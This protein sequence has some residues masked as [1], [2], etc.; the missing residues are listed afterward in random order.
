MSQF[1][2]PESFFLV[3]VDD[4]FN[5]PEIIV[6]Y[7]K[8]LSKRGGSAPGVRSQDIWEID[9]VLFQVIMKKILSCY[10]DLDYIEI[11][12]KNSFM[13]FQ[14]IS[15]YSED[16]NDI[17]NRGWIHQDFPSECLLAGLIYL[18]PNIDPDSGTSLFDLKSSEGN[19]DIAISN[20]ASP[21]PYT[22]WKNQSQQSHIK[23]EE[24]FIEKVK[25]QNKFNRLILYDT[26]E[27]HRANSYYTGDGEDARLTLTFFVGGI[28]AQPLKRIKNNN[29]DNDI[30]LQIAKTKV[31]PMNG[32]FS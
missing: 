3:I 10:F 13:T 11:S 2:K 26:R 25:I 30:K 9:N 17:K 28:N 7:G 1:E 20:L 8:S 15:R 21:N 12:W 18:T 16:K 6:E 19:D 29:W 5:D 14:E 4:F 22:K 23:Y 24:K 32:V 27:W 31:Q